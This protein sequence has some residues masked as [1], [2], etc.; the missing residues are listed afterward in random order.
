MSEG[1]LILGVG[2]LLWADEG[3]GP[4]LIELLVQR[5][6]CGAAELMDGGTQGLYLL[7]A[8]T[9]AERVILL[10]A[11]D[12]GREPGD[13]VVLEGD[14]ISALGRGRPLSLHQTSLHDLL[15]AAT[16]IGW[17]PHG[18]WLVGIQAAETEAWGQPLTP[19]VAAAMPRAAAM[20]EDLV[21]D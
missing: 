14:E 9:A 11:V 1:T 4:R 15:A 18:L 21:K 16:M 3:V 8:L 20:V 13:I 7:P 17:V 2:N 10:D 12:L 6:R 19:R 5:G